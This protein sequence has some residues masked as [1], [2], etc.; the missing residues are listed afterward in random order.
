MYGGRISSIMDI[1]TIDGNKKRHSW[2]DDNKNPRKI[3]ARLFCNPLA[4]YKYLVL[5]TNS[6]F[7]VNICQK[8]DMDKS[9]PFARNPIK[10]PSIGRTNPVIKP[11]LT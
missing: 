8:V 4:M 10:N 11:I 1:T 2:I 5:V 6:W 9:P 3:C 7:W